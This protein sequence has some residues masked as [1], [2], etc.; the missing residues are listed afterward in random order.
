MTMLLPIAIAFLAGSAVLQPLTRNSSSAASRLGILGCLVGGGAA[1]LAAGQVLLDQESLV[2][3]FDWAIPAGTLALQLDPLAA[4]F[5][6]PIA[7]LGSCCAIYGARYLR[8]EGV[9]RPLALHWFFYNLLFAALLLVVTAANTLL[10]L[11]AWELMTLASFFLVAWDHQTTEVRQAAWLYLLAAHCGLMLL[12]A[13]FIQAGIFCDSFNFADFTS[14]ARSSV[15]MANLFFLLALCGFGVKAGLL[16]LHIWLPDAHPAAPS[17]VSALMSGVLVKTG[18]YGILRVLTWLPPA[19][20]WW[21]WLLAVL[22][23][24]GALYGIILACLQSDIKRALAYSTIENVGIILLGLGFGM[25]AQA[26][27]RPA[28]ALLAYAGGLLH[29][30]NHALFKGLMFLGAGALV[31]A[32]GTRDMNRMGG[33]LKRMPLAGLLW[34]GGSLAISALPPLNG[35]ASEWLIYLG[36]LKAGMATDGFMALPALLLI[37]LLGLVGALAL[38]TFSRLV[39][40]CLLGEPRTAMARHAHDVSAWMLLPMALLLFGCLLIGL[41]PQAALAL[42]QGPLAS[43]LR[44]PVVEFPVPLA[45]F[46]QAG[47]FLLLALGL[48]WLL[49]RWLQQRRPRAEGPTWGCGFSFPNPRMSYTGAA[50]SELL[51]RHVLPKLVQPTIDQVAATGVFP[52]GGLLRQT[53]RDPLLTR[54]WRPLFVLIAER[55]Q[56]LR[57]LQ[58]GRLSIYLL[59]MFILSTLL[60][61]WSTW[62]GKG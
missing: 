18:I 10:F 16:P 58:Q 59:Y 32:T 29:I 14:L 26:E 41:L 61:A 47:F 11:A 38:L 40:I 44:Q 37:G 49:L 15:G 31:H 21:G 19:P 23:I 43:L 3:S 25:V 7:L 48:G 30:W 12:L 28:L 22:G 20:A 35:L 6:L 53:S 8:E 56:Q 24:A 54:C 46:G 17:H 45:R 1:L 2:W 13:L 60:L 5:V 27:G 50:Y 57:W 62:T 36:L 9:R 34:I 42:L 39:G 4:C 33:L 55:C 51:F 52:T